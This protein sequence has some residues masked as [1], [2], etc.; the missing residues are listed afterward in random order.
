MALPIAEL[1]RLIAAKRGGR[2]IRAAAADVGIS[3]ATLSRVEN[4][5]MP[6]LA[7]FAKICKW[8]DRDPREF[9]GLEMVETAAPAQKAVVHF[10]KKKTVTVE[11]AAALGELILAAQRAVQARDDLI[12]Q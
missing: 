11:T 3:Q 6:D 10:R 9:L 12:G 8:L 7:T 1:G 2:G 5:H 4:G